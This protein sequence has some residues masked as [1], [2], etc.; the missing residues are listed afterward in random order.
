MFQNISQCAH[1]IK[2][3][4]CIDIMDFLFCKLPMDIIKS[5][6]L[7]D[8]H[9]IVRNGEIT[10]IIPK[11]DYRYNLLQTITFKSCIVEKFHDR[12]RYNYNLYNLQLRQT[13]QI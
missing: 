11:S 7:F 12:I 13:G 10:T 3:N 1:Y 8:K 2:T 9:F 5:I 6:L 4:I